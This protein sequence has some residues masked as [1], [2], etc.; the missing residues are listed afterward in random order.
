MKRLTAIACMALVAGPVFAGGRLDRVALPGTSS[1]PGLQDATFVGIFWDDRCVN[2]DYVV[3]NVAA[4]PGTPQEISPQRI[5]EELQA[6][7]NQWNNIPTSYINM[8]IVAVRSLNN[9]V[10]RFDFIN[11]LTFEAPP[12]SPFLASSPSA[13]LFQDMDFLVG[14]DIDLDGDSDV[15]DPKV[16]GRNTCF[17]FDQDGDIEFPAGFYKAGAILDNDVQFNSGVA[18]ATQPGNDALTDIRAVS[19][20]EFGHS[21]GLS[22]SAMNQISPTN[23]NG[24]TMFPFID[25][26]DGNSETAQR[27]LHS[28]DIAWSSFIYQEGSARTGPA[29]LQRGDRA[30]RAE[31]G[32]IKGEIKTN[33]VGVAGASVQAINKNGVRVAEAFSGMTRLFTADPNNAPLM[34]ISPAA[35]AAAGLPASSIINGNYTIPVPRGLYDINVEA[36]DNFPVEFFRISNNTNIGG[37]LGQN[38]FPEEFRSVGPLEDNIELLPALSVPVIVVNGL[39]NNNNDITTN[40][41][42]VLRNSGPRTFV[43]TGLALNANQVIYADRFTNAQVIAAMDAGSVV[44]SIL[45]HTSAFD[46][47]QV[48]V[49]KRAGLFLGRVNPDGTANVDLTAPIFAKEN[50]VGQT[51]DLAPLYPFASVAQ[52]FELRRKLKADPTLDAFVVLEANDVGVAQ[53]GPSGIPPLLA[54]SSVAAPGRSFFSSNGGPLAPTVTGNLIELRFSGV[55]TDSVPTAAP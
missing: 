31:F 23:G 5:R 53:V 17:D 3:D 20:H 6:S 55:R 30:F 33:G 28:D 21:H 9:G 39:V 19:T 43:G 34:L 12:N 54:L 49:F 25:A 27:G 48:P 51:N 46:A 13:S 47:S 1:N 10:R 42:V 45:F 4:N 24:S 37:M 35:A 7:L 18:W 22:H 52:N 29:A 38:L 36:L 15:F 41:E 32:L 11:E 26:R 16:A 14:D 40:D 8:N 50:F 44:T 2:V